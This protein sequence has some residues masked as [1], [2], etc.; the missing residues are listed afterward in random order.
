LT[1][2][3]LLLLA[4][5]RLVPIG[6]GQRARGGGLGGG[7]VRLGLDLGLL[8]H[9][10]PVGDGDLLLRGEAG[11]LGRLASAC[12]GDR[13]DLADASRL[14]PAEV[15]EVRAV[16]GDVLD[17]ERVEVE[18]LAGERGLRLL[19]DPLRERRAV[20][21]DLLHRHRADDR[22]QCAREHLLREGLDLLLLGEEA[23]AGSAERPGQRAPEASAADDQEVD[24]RPG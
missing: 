13:G 15:G 2:G 6:L 18:A 10:C 4:E 7:R 23:L 1:N 22:A 5:D 19:G 11:L 17:L 8:E 16:V 9:E 24:W 21:D 12:F 20:T 3:Y 14:G